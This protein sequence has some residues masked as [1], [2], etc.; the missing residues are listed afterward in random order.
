VTAVPTGCGAGL[1]AVRDVSVSRPPDEG[2]EGADCVGVGVEELEVP[3]LIGYAMLPFDWLFSYM[4]ADDVALRTQ[5]ATRYAEL[6]TVGVHVH[7]LAVFQSR[8]G[9]QLP[10][11][12]THHLY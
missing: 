9:Y 11:S 10:P 6:A 1:F 4:S 5:T 3:T 12:Y 7:V 2:A 8:V